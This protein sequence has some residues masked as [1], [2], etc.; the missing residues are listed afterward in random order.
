MSL[1][2]VRSRIAALLL[3]T[4][5]LHIITLLFAVDADSIITAVLGIIYLGMGYMMLRDGQAVLYAGIV[6]PLVSITLTAAGLASTTSLPLL[7]AILFIV[8]DVLV[9]AGCV[10]L[11]TQL[12]TRARERV[13]RR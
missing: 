8:L 3:I 7:L 4:G 9:I 2:Y 12:R 10:Y 1:A 11:L 5:A 13:L 6:V